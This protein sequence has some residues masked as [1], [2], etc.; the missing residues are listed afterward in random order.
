MLSYRP[1]RHPPLMLLAWT[2]SG[3]AALLPTPASRPAGGD[4]ATPGPHRTASGWL[5]VR[6]A[7]ELHSRYSHDGTTP[8]PEIARLAQAADLD[9]IVISDHNTL[10]ARSDER[11]TGRPLVLAGVEISSTPGHL[12]ALGIQ[13]EI[14]QDQP[15]E[16][17]V[18]AIHAQ[19][20]LAIAADPL[21]R[22]KRW[23]R[24]DLPV[25]GLI[26]V[27]LN[28]RLLHSPLPWVLVKALL[29]PNELFWR[30]VA[31]R[32]ADTL[33]LWD[34]QLAVRPLVGLA[35][36]D[37]HAHA[38]VSPFVIDSFSSGFRLVSM[39]LLVHALTPEQLY[40]ALRRGRGYLGFDGVADPRPFEYQLQGPG[41][42]VE[43]GDR[44]PWGPGL[45]AVVRLPRTGRIT[46]MQ[47][48][49]PAVRVEDDHLTWP[50]PGPGVYRLEVTRRGA[51][52]IL[53]NP[54]YVEPAL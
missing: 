1:M 23:T 19:G 49:R 30:T 44:V 32:P 11:L 35:S 48:G 42:P 50:I 28:D 10:A 24:W 25:D 16:R 40:E 26:I 14:S 6:G 36:H 45:T 8:V 13:R 43:M 33:A 22:K 2:L 20:G 4:A 54:I 7:L 47:D 38:G 39:H 31:H 18:E 46:L 9:F 3:C 51:L 37:T 21:S 29:L 15:V 12:L 17:I 53:S 41:G 34:A 27:D 52:W 5:D